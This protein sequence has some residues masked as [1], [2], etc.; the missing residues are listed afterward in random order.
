MSPQP[1]G[2]R[3]SLFRV[4]CYTCLTMHSSWLFD[5][6]ILV[7]AALGS[8]RCYILAD[9]F[10]WKCE[11]VHAFQKNV[12]EGLNCTFHLVVAI[13]SSNEVR[14]E[15]WCVLR[16]VQVRS[17]VRSLNRTNRTAGPEVRK[18]LPSFNV[19]YRE[20]TWIQDTPDESS[21]FTFRHRIPHSPRH[22]HEEVMNQEREE[23]NTWRLVEWGAGWK[24]VKAYINIL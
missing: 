12:C 8:T 20:V 17:V 4:D 3:A 2:K 7:I 11:C 19:W 16:V 10:R 23:T 13:T 24:K 18:L 6:L 14:I 22:T 21:I 5:W 15:I 1:R 9:T